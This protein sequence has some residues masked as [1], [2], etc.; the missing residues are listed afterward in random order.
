MTDSPN[1]TDPIRLAQE[2]M[3]R[4][5]PKRFYKEAGYIPAERGFA[6]QLD[7][8]A[9]RTPNRAAL[10]VPDRRLATA[11]VAEWNAQQDVIA[12]TAMPLT[13]IVNAAIDGVA[14]NMAAVKADIVAYAGADLVC[15]RAEAPAGLAHRQHEAW[16]PLIDWAAQELGVHFRV[17]EGVMHVDQDANTVAAIDRALAGEDA[18][19]LAAIHTITTIGGSAIIALAV[20]RGRLSAAQAWAAA[21]VDEDWQVEQWG[22]DSEAAA[23]RADRRRELVAAAFI[24]GRDA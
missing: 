6:I 9:A 11:L 14:A 13:R 7:G 1:Q 22:E 8:K 17:V 18:F 24:L 4:E 5:L 15:Y 2:K 23:R 19:R 21:G 3:R 16:T 20:A 12:P 10:A